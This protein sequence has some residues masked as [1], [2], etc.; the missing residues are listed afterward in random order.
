MTD[1]C[2]YVGVF[3][4]QVKYVSSVRQSLTTSADSSLT[5]E[6]RF[7]VVALND[8]LTFDNQNLKLVSLCLFVIEIYA[9]TSMFID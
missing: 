9:A 5:T 7:N 3:R 2:D 6:L 4:T 8:I 1:Y